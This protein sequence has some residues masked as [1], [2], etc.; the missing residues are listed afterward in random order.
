V[1]GDPSVLPA[2]QGGPFRVMIVDDSA[3]IRGIVTRWIETDPQIKIVGSFPNGLQAVRNIEK[4]A[5]EVVILDIEM[6]EMDGMTA[7]PELIKI[8]PGVQIIMSSTLTRRN[9][10]ISLKAMAAGAADYIPK[11]ESTRMSSADEFRVELVGKVK[12]YA[13]KSR[14]R[15]GLPLPP[16]SAPAASPASP[17]PAVPRAGASAAGARTSAAPPARPLWAPPPGGKLTLQRQSNIK[18]AIL[19]IGS[20]TGGPQA[21]FKVI[22]ALGPS[23][24]VPIV[25]TQH[26][27]ATFTAILAEHITSVAKRPAKEAQTGDVLEAGKVYVAPGDYHMIIAN[28]G[29]R[30]VIK[31]NQ[32]PP[33][34]FCRPAVDP[35][36]RSL[37][38]VYGPAVLACVL[39]GM[40]ADGRE[41][42]RKLVDAGSTVIAQDEATSVVWGMPGAVATAGLAAAILPLD[43]I[44]P[45]LDKIIRGGRI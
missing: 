37:A 9:A 39:T 2:A 19:A 31:L 28:E 8:L 14:N 45:T 23:L 26:M 33:E 6:P 30:K 13:T 42:A 17:A 3:I 18:P 29:T 4:V 43:Q 44:G 24:P 40:G 1:A 34:N 21:L 41:G 20:S 36:Y 5:P 32:D 27:P 10:E 25:V 11:P 22:A 15:A 12:A 16:A 38:A 7:L 35:M